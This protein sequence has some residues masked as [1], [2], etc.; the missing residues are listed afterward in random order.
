MLKLQNTDNEVRPK[1]PSEGALGRA[2]RSTRS[3]STDNPD[4]Q[5]AY[6]CP[7]CERSF[8]TA[9]G[10]RRHHFDVHGESIAGDPVDCAY[11]GTTLRREPWRVRK[12]DRQFCDDDCQ[13]SWQSENRTGESAYNYDPETWVEKPCSWCGETVRRQRA[14]VLESGRVYCDRSCFESWYSENMSGPNSQHW[15]G[16]PKP[17]GPGWTEDKREAVRE[18]DGREC[19]AC[20]MAEADHLESVGR[21]LDV[22]HLIDP[23][24]STNP[25]VYN[26]MRNLESRCITCHQ[27]GAHG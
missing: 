20:G 13:M 12:Y 19:V 27:S 17:Y 24:E 16:G 2:S 23:R 1:K 25:A 6:D 3:M 18:R 21:R 11:C 10:M 9:R 26:A 5:D 8:S 22:H 7:S 4:S 15:K 14:N